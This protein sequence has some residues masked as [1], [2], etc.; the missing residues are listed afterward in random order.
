MEYHI[1]KTGKDCNEGS[2]QSPFL[3][4]SRAAEIA[5]AGDRIVVHEG[6]YR[7]WVSPVN[8]GNSDLDRI[9]YEAA[10]GEKVIIKGSEIISNWIPYKENVFSVTLNNEL[11]GSY[12]PY[13]QAI[14]GDWM[15]EPK[16]CKVHTGEVYLNGIALYEAASLQD[17]LNPQK[18][19]YPDRTFAGCSRRNTG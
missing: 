4:I 11:F 7:E 16:K 6:V 14:E 2:Y 19:E 1:A 18:R 12:N 10:K 17:V 5:E 9:T 8:A 15:V 13:E 3:S